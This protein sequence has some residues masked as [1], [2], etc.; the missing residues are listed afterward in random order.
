MN[1]GAPFPRGVPPQLPELCPRAPPA[2]SRWRRGPSRRPQ[3][4]GRP[5]PA[6]TLPPIIN[7]HFCFAIKEQRW[8][9]ILARAALAYVSMDINLKIKSMPPPPGAGGSAAARPQEEA[10]RGCAVA[11]PAGA[12]KDAQP[13]GPHPEATRGARAVAFPQGTPPRPPPPPSPCHE[14]N[15]L[16]TPPPPPPY[17]KKYPEYLYILELR[18]LATL[19]QTSKFGWERREGDE[20]QRKVGLRNKSKGSAKRA[21]RGPAPL[22]SRW[23]RS[24]AWTAGS[25]SAHT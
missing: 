8:R 23:P 17:S 16:T 21:A 4:P 2:G 7:K 1:K 10:Q 12:T 20:R 9:I 22:A 13:A 11:V 14:R 25:P 19:W 3:A 18:F 6:P 15:Y 5:L 24:S